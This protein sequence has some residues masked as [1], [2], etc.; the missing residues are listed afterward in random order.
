MRRCRRCFRRGRMRLRSLNGPRKH[1]DYI[2]RVASTREQQAIWELPKDLSRSPAG[3]DA[4]Q[5]K[6][7]AA[8]RDALGCRAETAAPALSAERLAGTDRS[9]PYRPCLAVAAGGDA[10]EGQPH[11][12]HDD[13]V[14]GPPSGLSLQRLDRPALRLSR[15]GRSEARRGD[16]E[17]G[18]RRPMGADRRDVGRA[19]HQHADGGVACAAAALRPALFRKA[20]RQ[21]PHR[22]LA[23]RLLRLLAGPAAAAAARRNRAASSRSR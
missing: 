5:R 2:A 20:V 9:C 3:L 21:P 7:V 19:R 15:G 4:A 8:A 10:A 1:A 23:A 6:S 17:E 11:V 14:D 12:P 22:L 16:Q 13:P 18:C